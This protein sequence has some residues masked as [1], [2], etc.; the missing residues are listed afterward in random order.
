MMMRRIVP[1]KTPTKPP[2]KLLT[3]SPT[4]PLTLPPKKNEDAP[5]KKNEDAP[6]KKNEDAPPAKPQNIATGQ[7][8]QALVDLGRALK[9]AF[10]AVHKVELLPYPRNQRALKVSPWSSNP[11]VQNFSE[12]TRDEKEEW[13]LK[14]YTMWVFIQALNFQ[15]EDVAFEIADD[16]KKLPIP[17]DL[18]TR[19][20]KAAEVLSTFTEFWGYGFHELMLQATSFCPEE[21]QMLKILREIMTTIVKFSQMDQLILSFRPRIDAVEPNIAT[22]FHLMSTSPHLRGKYVGRFELLS[23]GQEYVMVHKM[24][25]LLADER[26]SLLQQKEELLAKFA[27]ALRTTFLRFYEERLKSR[28]ISKHHTAVDPEHPKPKKH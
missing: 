2:T 17:P 5:P 3:K 26:N 22:S 27:P 23:Q 6:P 4:K 19:V 16:M 1:A 14:E 28:L 25:K 10:D 18:K 9:A 15:T 13:Y 20:E 7:P 21:V 8:N 24:V 12:L 11:E